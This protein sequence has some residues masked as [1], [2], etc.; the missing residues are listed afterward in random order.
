MVGLAQSFPE[1]QH[2]RSKISSMAQI[3]EP[4]FLKAKT[5]VLSTYCPG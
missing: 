1:D 3:I 5:N 2:L 4:I